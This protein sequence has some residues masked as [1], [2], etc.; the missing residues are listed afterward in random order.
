M[1]YHRLKRLIG[2][3]LMLLLAAP[4]AVTAAD[5][6]TI[7]GQVNE[8]YQI[9]DATGQ[10][11]EVADTTAGNELVEN[12]IGEKAKVTGTIE[13]DQDVKIIT[14]TSFTIIAD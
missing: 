12:H 9:V 13:L 8:N 6:M 11:Y 14:V 1:S 5:P 2:V 4:L 3:L 10:I 7:Q